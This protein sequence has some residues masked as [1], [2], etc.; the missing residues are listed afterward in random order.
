MK[1]IK[2]EHSCVVL[3]K[4]SQSLVIDPGELSQSYQV[5]DHC[6]GI[7]VTHEHFDH[8]DEAKLEQTLTQNPDAK[9]YVNQSIANL[10][11]SVPASRVVV[12]NVG[13]E[14]AADS[15]KLVF[16]GGTH[17]RVRPEIEPCENT[18]VIVDDVFY[19][20]GDAHFVPEQPIQWLGVPLN[21]PW[22]KVSETNEFVKTIKASHVLPIHDGLLDKAGLSTYE[23]HVTAAC[24]MAGST[25]H[26]LR[27]GGSIELV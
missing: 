4:S 11:K 14:V 9:L 18:G 24:D 15:F 20:P 19:Q 23:S 5:P 17:E 10:L 13:D 22:S 3:E 2:Y 16:V 12:V 27:V 6:V 7:V 21:A 26:S 1:L 8:F 25:Y